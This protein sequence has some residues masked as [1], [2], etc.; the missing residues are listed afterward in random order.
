MEDGEQSS[1]KKIWGAHLELESRNGLSHRMESPI[2][3]DV[4]EWNC[5]SDDIWNQLIGLDGIDRGNQSRSLI[6]ESI[7]WNWFDWMIA[8]IV[9]NQLI[10]LDEIKWSDRMESAGWNRRS[11][12]G[13]Y[14]S[15]TNRIQWNQ[16]NESIQISLNWLDWMSLIRL[17]TET[18]SRWDY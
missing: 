8:S 6:G 1:R 15:R 13:I 17:R 12:D 9:W 14:W 4:I 7:V 18:S 2:E 3:R 16:S 11:I 5:Q 10:W